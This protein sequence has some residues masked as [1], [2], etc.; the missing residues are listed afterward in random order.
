MITTRTDTVTR[1][2]YLWVHRLKEFQVQLITLSQKLGPVREIQDA[3]NQYL[4]QARHAY[5]NSIDFY[6]VC[7]L[8]FLI[9]SLNPSNSPEPECLVRNVGLLFV[10]PT[11]L[12]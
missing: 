2:E 10:D 4:T 1:P 11:E 8:C 6:S 12:D 7:E 9:S 3:T 5:C